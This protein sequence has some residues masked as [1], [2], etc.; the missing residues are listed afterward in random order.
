[1]PATLFANTERIGDALFVLIPASA[2]GMSYFYDDK[3]GTRQFIKG[4]STNMAITLALKQVINKTRP[5]GECCD[6]FPSG[7]ASVAFQGASFIQ[8][9]Y[10][11]RYGFPAY[12]GATYTG[13][14]R[15][16]VD[17]HYLDDVLAGA[18]IG[19]ASSYY[20]TESEN[21]INLSA[22]VV[23]GRYGVSISY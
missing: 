5:D 7:H 12:L 21:K 1:M 8:K 15:I 22:F 23:E 20:F 14:S 10:G 2:A 17:K 18:L 9:R 16:A 3:E 13:Y 4:F 6:S 19:M 11:W